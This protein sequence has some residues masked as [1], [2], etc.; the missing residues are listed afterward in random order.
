[1]LTAEEVAQLGP[2]PDPN[3]V[4]PTTSLAES[5]SQSSGSVLVAGSELEVQS[6]AQDTIPDPA[7]VSEDKY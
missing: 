1:M 2:L 5:R 6:E 7:P 4:T 3:V